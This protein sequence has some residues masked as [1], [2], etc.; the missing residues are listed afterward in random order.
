M[1]FSFFDVVDLFVGDVFVFCLDGF[2]VYFDDVEMVILVVDNLVCDVCE[3]LIDMVCWWV[4]GI[5]D[6]LLLVIIKLVEVFFFKV[7][8]LIGFVLCVRF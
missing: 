2:W 3:V 6:N 7:V 4:C 1:K 8:L 5:G